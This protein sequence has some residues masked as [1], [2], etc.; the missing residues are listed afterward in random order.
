MRSRCRMSFSV[1]PAS[2][3]TMTLLDLRS[4]AIN[5]RFQNG[6]ASPSSKLFG[7]AVKLLT[8][9]TASIA[10]I[11]RVSLWIRPK[12]RDDE[13]SRE[14]TARMSSGCDGKRRS[15][16][17]DC[18]N[19]GSLVEKKNFSSTTGLR[20]T[21]AATSPSNPT[22]TASIHECVPTARFHKLEFRFDEGVIRHSERQPCDDH[23]RKRLAWNIDTAPKTVGPKKDTSR[24]CFELLEQFPAR[25]ASALHKKIQFLSQKKFT[26]L[27]GHLLHAAITRKKDKGASV[28][29]LDKM[30]DPMLERFLVACVARVRHFSHD[31]D[32]H[33]RAKIERTPEQHRFDFICP[34]ALTKIGEIRTAD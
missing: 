33:L 12:Y 4:L 16:F 31:K 26:N 7:P 28:R 29:F 11:S 32:C 9:L 6:L 30:R 22:V 21:K 25:R 3:N 8:V 14:D 19:P 13:I 23:I 10:W 1:S 27:I 15:I 17:L 34:D 2:V 5:S 24:C 20:S 18:P